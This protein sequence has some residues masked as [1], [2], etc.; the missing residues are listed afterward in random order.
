MDAIQT[1][2]THSA[3]AVTKHFCHF[4]EGRK[5]FLLTDHKLLTYALASHT[6]K[7]SPR[8]VRHLDF[9]SQF[10]SDICHVTD[11]RNAAA[12]ALSWIEV[13]AVKQRILPAIDFDAMARAQAGDAELQALQSSSTTLKFAHIPQFASETII[14]CDTS[15]GIHRPF[16][17][18]DFR[19]T[20]FESL[21]SLSHPGIRAT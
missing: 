21:H 4:V 11:I 15:T 14:I 8:Q 16:V 17:P 12:D 3:G 1:W 18:D 9:I 20:V 6:D 10:N 19:R 5:F 13:N 2:E 7:Y